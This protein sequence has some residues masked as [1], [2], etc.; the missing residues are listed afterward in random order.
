[1]LEQFPPSE[2][3]GLAELAEHHAFPGVMATDHFQPWLPQHGQSAHVWSV[4]GALEA[5]TR[6]N[7]GPGATTPTFRSHP[8]VV[9]QASATLAAMYPGRHWPGIGSGAALNEHVVGPY[10]PEARERI[11]HMFEAIQL[12]QKLFAASLAGRDVRHSGPTFQLE[13]ARLWTMPLSLS[14]EQK[15]DITDPIEMERAA[16]ALPIERPRSAGSSAPT[17]TRSSR[18]SRDTSTLA[19]FTSCSTHPTARKRLQ[20]IP[21]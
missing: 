20:G 12:I 3:I 5:R 8:A 16:D 13:S 14:K 18:R 1:M 19:S 15:H 21:L 2:V 7:F 9:A 17:L 10:W 11:N 6:G 4:L